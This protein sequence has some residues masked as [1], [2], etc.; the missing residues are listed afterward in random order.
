[1]RYFIKICHFESQ[2]EL[3]LNFIKFHGI[4]TEKEKVININSK[5]DKLI[6]KNEDFM[7]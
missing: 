5:K 2:G 7:I 4:Q 3:A 1:M 6:F